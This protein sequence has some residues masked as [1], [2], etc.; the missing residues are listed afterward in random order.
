MLSFFLSSF[1]VIKRCMCCYPF[2]SAHLNTFLCVIPNV[3]SYYLRIINSRAHAFKLISLQLAFMHVNVSCSF[4][5]L[6]QNGSLALKANPS[7]R[8]SIY[9]KVNMSTKMIKY[10]NA[11]LKKK[12]E[13]Y[14]VLWWLNWNLFGFN[15]FSN[16]KQIHALLS[17]D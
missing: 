16:M 11:R 4:E 3:E 5:M 12:Y 6:L 10:Y 7:L 17:K 13:L 15:Q 8:N 9:D 2:K 14:V 1:R